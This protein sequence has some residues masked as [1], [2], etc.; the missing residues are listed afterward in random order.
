M[1][2]CCQP[3]EASK[4]TPKQ[5]AHLDHPAQ[6]PQRPHQGRCTLDHMVKRRSKSAT[7]PVSIPQCGL[8]YRS[9]TGREAS[10]DLGYLLAW[11][12][13]PLEPRQGCPGKAGAARPLHIIRIHLHMFFAS[14]L[15]D[16]CSSGARGVGGQE[17]CTSV[18]QLTKCLL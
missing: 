5:P 10:A 16:N 3:L 18:Y 11:E 8:S 17:V 2:L 1:C 6:T 15:Q 13:S 12:Q 14:S 9:E 7:R 4:E